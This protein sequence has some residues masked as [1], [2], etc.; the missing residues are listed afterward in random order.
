MVRVNFLI[1][2]L[3]FYYIVYMKTAKGNSS[4]T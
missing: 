3:Q 1:K 4:F 2:F